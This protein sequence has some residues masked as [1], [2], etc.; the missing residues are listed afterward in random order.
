MKLILLLLIANLTFASDGYQIKG[1]IK[2]TTS[3]TIKISRYNYWNQSATVID[4]AEIKDGKFVFKGK[5]E[6]PELVG[7]TLGKWSASFFLE[8]SDIDM[9]LDTSKF[10]V[11]EVHGSKSQE[12]LE[13]FEF[14]EHR[15]QL[16]KAVREW[17][18]SYIFESN[19]AKLVDKKEQYD[20]VFDLLTKE[21]IVRLEAM[22]NKNPGSIV[23][24]Y[25]LYEMIASHAHLKVDTIENLLYKFTGEAQ[26]S[27]YYKVIKD[28]IDNRRTLSGGSPAP[29]FNNLS[30]Y[31]GSYLLLAFYSKTD[32]ES[33]YH[34][35]KVH[36]VY[37]GKGLEIMHISDN[38]KL[39]TLYKAYT[40]PFY[41][42]IDKQGKIITSS[43][44]ERDI[45]N[46]LEELL[47]L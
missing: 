40:I 39:A 38:K 11:I 35:K 9:K 28:H 12:E 16:K 29:D 32:I 15:V 43:D 47:P 3:G 27:I 26:Q 46:K 45:D 42:L 2:G 30:Y 8:N 44:Y 1:T 6:R 10:A 25:L 14:D 22:T 24:A 41:V 5:I 7:I 20:S 31:Q 21:D 4:S 33:E 19:V 18:R 17:E 23:N 13:K 37:H 36:R 34:C